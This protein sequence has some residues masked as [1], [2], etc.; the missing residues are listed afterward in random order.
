M[1]DLGLSRRAVLQSAALAG[2]SLVS[3][4]SNAAPPRDVPWLAEIQQPPDNVPPDAPK[5]SDVLIDRDGGRIATLDGWN[6]RREELRR[7]WL[8]FLGPMPAQRKGAP[9]VRVLEE[10]YTQGVRRLL[11]RYEIE[12]GVSTEA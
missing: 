2:V 4:R 9:L 10:V 3:K 8:D 12:P 11:V 7:W 5:P 6:K 1:K